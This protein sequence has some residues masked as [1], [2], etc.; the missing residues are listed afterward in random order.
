M[1]QSPSLPPLLDSLLNVSKKKKKQ[2]KDFVEEFRKCQAIS[3]Y[4]LLHTPIHISLNY[5]KVDSSGPS[6]YHS[7]SSLLK[8][9]L[10]YARMQQ[11][12]KVS[13]KV[14]YINIIIIIIVL[15]NLIRHHHLL[16]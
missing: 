16:Q 5:K 13:I 12:S 4:E 8:I 7:N 11:D 2:V 3:S 6:F 10:F 14:I 15:S 1:I 9:F